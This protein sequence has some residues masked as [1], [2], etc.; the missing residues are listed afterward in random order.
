MASAAVTKRLQSEL[1]GLM[2]DPVPGVTAFPD[3]DSLTRWTGTLT[4]DGDS[5]YAGC[6]FTLS[7]SFAGNYPLVPPSVT[8]VTPIFHPN[9]DPSGAICLDLLKDA[10]TPGLTVR[11]LLISILSL[12][13]APNNASPLNGEAARLWDDRDA[14][15][16]TARAKYAAEVGGGRRGGRRRRE[17]KGGGGGTTPLAVNRSGWLCVQPRPCPRVPCRCDR[18]GRSG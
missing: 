12:L 18:R 6:A 5:V 11:T 14:F 13:D 3:G 9:C 17:W 7:L 1:M 15:V 16:A 8:F 10:W 4:C 2:M